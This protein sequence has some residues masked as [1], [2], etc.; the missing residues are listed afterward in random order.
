MTGSK[1]AGPG[2]EQ[3]T[4]LVAAVQLLDEQLPVV[5]VI[6]HPEVARLVDVA[7]QP[8]SLVHPANPVGF[9]GRMTQGAPSQ[10]F[11]QSRP[12]PGPSHQSAANQ[13]SDLVLHCQC[14]LVIGRKKLIILPVYSR[15]QDQKLVELLL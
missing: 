10:N 4:H 15:K 13:Q 6:V 5:E 11:R 12:I 8:G 3:Q 2:S 7:Q 1:Q 14:C 9:W